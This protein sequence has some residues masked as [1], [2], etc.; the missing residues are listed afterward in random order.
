[1][2]VQRMA[3]DASI[4]ACTPFVE[5]EIVTSFWIV[6]VIHDGKLKQIPYWAA[7]E[8]DIM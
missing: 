3:A 5:D 1:M 7:A 2:S 4:V 6:F 8:F